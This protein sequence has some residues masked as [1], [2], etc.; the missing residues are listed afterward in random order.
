[1]VVWE[2]RPRIGQL[3]AEDVIPA[4]G[5]DRIRG[6]PDG[7]RRH[8]ERPDPGHSEGR[9]G[10]QGRVGRCRRARAVE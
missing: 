9:R 10:L 3:I 7:F 5:P 2:D 1:M 8:G 4:A 6:G